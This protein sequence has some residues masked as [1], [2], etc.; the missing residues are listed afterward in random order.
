M[1]RELHIE[2]FAIID[3]LHLKLEPGFNILTGE[4]GAGKSILI[5]AVTLI[6][7][8][9]ADTTVLRRGANRARVEGMFVLS[10]SSQASLA[11]LLTRESLDGDTPEILWLSRELR[12]NGRSVA[13]VNGRVVSLSLRDRGVRG[14]VRLPQPCGLRHDGQAALP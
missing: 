3:D 1:L 10:S 14:R 7:G 9:R 13:R 11:E 8:S 2:D 4:T 6:L 12:A 5:D